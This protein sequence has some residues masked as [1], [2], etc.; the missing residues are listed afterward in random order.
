MKDIFKTIGAHVTAE[1]QKQHDPESTR[2]QS[3]ALRICGADHP[4]T[5]AWTHGELSDSEFHAEALKIREEPTPP[6]RSRKGE[7]WYQVGLLHYPMKR[8]RDEGKAEKE[9]TLLYAKS[10]LGAKHKASQWAKS[11]RKERNKSHPIDN[12]WIEES[13][14]TNNYGKYWKKTGKYF[15]C[16]PELYLIPNNIEE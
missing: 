7:G 9:Q 8:N 13:T 3:V 12:A 6:S 15:S 14:R 2:M 11:I 1:Y 10:L 5:Q 16:N 4:L